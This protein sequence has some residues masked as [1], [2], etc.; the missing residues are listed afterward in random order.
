[1]L[2]GHWMYF[3]IMSEMVAPTDFPKVF[4]INAPLQLGMY[5]TVA[6]VGYYFLGSEGKH[7]LID[8]LDPGSTTR[9]V[10]QMMLFVHIS[11]AYLIKSVALTRFLVGHIQPAAL[12]SSS[13]A[14]RIMFGMCATT[15]LALGWVVAN[16]MPVFYDLVLSLIH[17]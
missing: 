5:M 16:S 1:M 6:V 8:N 14:S 9:F 7:Y 4:Y 15:I 2:V 10:V 17:I 11:I 13:P 3:E 12:E